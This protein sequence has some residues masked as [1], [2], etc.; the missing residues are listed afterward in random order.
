MSLADARDARR[1]RPC[2]P[3]APEGDR[4]AGQ[5]PQPVDRALRLSIQGSS[6]NCNLSR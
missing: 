4:S 6:G 1:S 3:F 5:N 2:A